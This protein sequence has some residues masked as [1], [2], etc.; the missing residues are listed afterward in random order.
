MSAFVLKPHAGCSM[1][2]RLDGL[3]SKLTLLTIAFSDPY[4]VRRGQMCKSSASS[5]HECYLHLDPS[6]Q[7]LSLGACTRGRGVLN[8]LGNFFLILSGSTGQWLLRLLSA[9]ILHRN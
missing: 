9:Q 4:K 1:E 7:I 2:N 8:I 3:G 6:L 5:C